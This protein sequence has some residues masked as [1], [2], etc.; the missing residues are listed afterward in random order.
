M[1]TN[2][3]T[4]GPI[5]RADD[6]WAIEVHEPRPAPMGEFLKAVSAMVDAYARLRDENDRLRGMVADVSDE[7]LLARVNDVHAQNQFLRSTV[8]ALSAGNTRVI[9][10]LREI[11]EAD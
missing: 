1:N 6:R 10:E 5:N 9:S 4:S 8:A 2:N 11:E 3:T 7:T